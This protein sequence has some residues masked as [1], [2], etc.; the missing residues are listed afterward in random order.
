MQSYAIILKK[1]NFG[2]KNN[3]FKNYFIFKVFLHPQTSYHFRISLFLYLIF[4]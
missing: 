4:F 2:Y 3:K 1:Q